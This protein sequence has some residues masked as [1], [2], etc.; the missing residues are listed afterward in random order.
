M[1]RKRILTIFLI[2]ILLF[3]VVGCSNNKTETLEKEV[4]VTE[5]KDNE[6]DF[7]DIRKEVESA[8]VFESHRRIIMNKKDDSQ[9]MAIEVQSK[10]NGNK[11]DSV[12]TIKSENVEYSGNIISM[13]D[14]SYVEVA[15]LNELLYNTFFSYSDED[16]TETMSEMDKQL[17]FDIE[18][19]YVESFFDGIDKKY[20]QSTEDVMPVEVDMT[21]NFTG[22]ESLLELVDLYDSKLISK[23][24]SKYSFKLTKEILVYEIEEIANLLKKDTKTYVPIIYNLMCDFEELLKSFDE[25]SH[26]VITIEDVKDELSSVMSGKSS[27]ADYTDKLERNTGNLRNYL[28]NLIT[29]LPEITLTC[30]ITK[31]GN[32]YN[33]II[34]YRV[35][36]NGELMEELKLNE[37]VTVLNNID[38]SVPEDY[39][40]VEEFMNTPYYAFSQGDLDALLNTVDKKMR[41]KY[42]ADYDKVMEMLNSME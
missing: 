26:T 9:D 27:Y 23:N 11:K 33:S 22:S 30:E 16:E 2:V 24:G 37:T 29:I 35:E 6:I 32:V 38:I 4:N 19:I 34:V 36:Q 40:T 28:N 5:K 25:S 41:E 7:W 31:D 1:Y 15:L 10:N 18:N 21:I 12:V 17:K 14:Y 8:K 13:E 42:G 20:V 39:N 3:S